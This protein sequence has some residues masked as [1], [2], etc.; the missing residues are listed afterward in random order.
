MS[1]NS[2]NTGFDSP[3]PLDCPLTFAALVALLNELVHSEFEG[4]FIPYV[5]GAATPAVDDQNKV[6]HK[7]DSNGRPLGTYVFYSGTWRKQYS[8]LIGEVVMYSGDPAVDFAGTNGAGTV[9][10]EWDGWALCNG[11]NGTPNLSDK[12]VVGAKMD[13]LGVGYPTGGP[14]KSTVSGEA[15]QAED[16]VHEITLTQDNT[17]RPA[18]PALTVGRWDADGNAP[19]VGGGLYGLGSNTTIVPSDA[20]NPDPDAIPT[21]PNYYSLA[22]AQFRGY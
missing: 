10:G 12:F 4:D 2:I 3:D 9:S 22:F 20:G 1:V 7:V 8:G 14:W 5:T 11:N 18:V 17:F 6:W 16:G 13:D 19:N 21:L 15:Q